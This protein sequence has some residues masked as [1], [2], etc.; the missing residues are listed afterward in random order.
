MDLQILTGDFET[1]YDREY[2]LRNMT[3]VEY[4]CDPRFEAIG[5]SFRLDRVSL[6]LPAPP[7]PPHLPW[8]D[9]KARWIDGPDLPVIFQKIDWS[10]TAFMSHN[11]GFD[12]AILAWR[13]GIV[14]ALYIDTLGMARAALPDA[15]GASLE[16]VLTHIGAPPKGDAL[17]AAAGMRLEDIKRNPRYYQ[18]YKTY[19]NRDCDGCAWIFRYLAHAFSGTQGVGTIHAFEEFLQMDAVARMAI[20]PQFCLDMS[21]LVE[22]QR[23]TQVQKAM[24]LRRL[25]D[26]AILDP[27]NPKSDL[28]SNERFAEVL[29]KLGVEPPTKISFKT[30]K[31]TY[32]FSKTDPEFM[33]LADDEDPLVQAAVAARLGFKSTLEETRTKRFLAIAN[34]NW[35]HDSNESVIPAVRINHGVNGQ[36]IFP[37]RMPFPLRYSGAHTH[38]LSGEWLLNLQNLGRKSKLREALIAPPGY[39]IVSADASQIEARIVSWLAGCAKLVNAFANKEDVYSTFASIVYDY[40]VNKKDHPGER[41]VGKTGVLGLGFGM[42]AFKFVLTCLNQGRN[43]GLPLELCRIP[44]ELGERVVKL[45]RTEYREVPDYWSAQ[46]QVIHMLA[47]RVSGSLGVLLIDGPDQSVILPNG[48]RLYYRN[49]HSELLP[50]PG[51]TDMRQQWV[52]DYGREKKFTFGGKMTE[53]AVQALARIITMNAAAR[54]RKLGR[55]GSWKPH[56]LA[57]QIHDQLIYLA[58]KEVADDLLALVIE[59]MSRPLDWFATLPLDAEGGVGEN[60]MEIK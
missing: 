22:H 49:M 56:N 9:A 6:P 1:Y 26:S 19:A 25:R 48:M 60:L 23:S 33:E 32:A 51:S 40:L 5:C 14:P 21:V 2:S 45:Y 17:A 16:K 24:L 8:F 10:R 53:N 47:N 55:V 34:I 29:R 57:G 38:R 13:Y 31:Q 28:L 12:G 41:F 4:I 27:D 59:E 44:H 35:P 30:G 20:L 58:P 18:E 37:R 54:I 39:L 42:G 46:T 15:K 43:Q 3:P 11:I 52:F 36:P 50:V 7:Q